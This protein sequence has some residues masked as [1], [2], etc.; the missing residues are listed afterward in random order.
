MNPEKIILASDIS[1]IGKVAVTAALLL[2]AIC[3]LEVAVLPTALLSSHTG[4]FPNVYVEDYQTGMKSFLAQWKNLDLTFSA[5]V[6]G[7]C[8]S[9]SQLEQL[10]SFSRQKQLDII[11]DPIMGDQGTLYKGFDEAYVEAMKRVCQ[12]ATIIFPNLT[13]ASLLLGLPYREDGLSKNELRGLAQKLADLG[14]KIVCI[15]GLKLENNQI[16]LVYFHS[17]KNTFHLFSHKLFPVHFFGTG[18]ILTALLTSSFVQGI[19]FMKSIP[20]ILNFIEK[21]L[22]TTL[23]LKIDIRQGIYYQPYLG[24]LFNQFQQLLEEKNE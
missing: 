2:F 7:Y 22:T 21:S 19:D 11:V 12:Q 8:K 17:E 9:A 24:E 20:I 1:G 18:D 23:E 3:Q 4:G 5:M 14:P 6:I 13:E 16:G 15:T 10:L